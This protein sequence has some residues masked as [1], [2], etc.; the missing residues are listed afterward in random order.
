MYSDFSRSTFEQ[1]YQMLSK[2]LFSQTFSV[3][4]LNIP[5]FNYHSKMK[6]TTATV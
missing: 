6:N 2:Y 4:H 5:A 3:L 1:Q